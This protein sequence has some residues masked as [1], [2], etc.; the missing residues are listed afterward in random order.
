MTVSA[1]GCLFQNIG[2]WSGFTT[3]TTSQICLTVTGS[4]NKFDT[5]HIAGMADTESADH[6]GSRCLKIGSSG[7]GENEFV[8]CTIGVDTVTRSAANASIEFAGGTPRNKFIGCI[9]RILT[10][11]A[12]ALGIL[13]TGAS[14]MDRDQTFIDCQ[15][16]NQVKSTGTAMTALVTLPASAGGLILLDRCTVV[17]VTDLFSDSTTAAQMY[18]DGGPPTST[19]SGLAIN[20]A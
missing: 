8:N 12:T 4:Y 16:I 3:G 1:S 20:P 11:D 13:G 5:C 15:F 7:S 17:G 19:T 6:A 10:D 14:C 9:N 18:V 2:L